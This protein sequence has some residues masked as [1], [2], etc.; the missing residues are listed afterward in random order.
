MAY[1]G[2]ATIQNSGRGRYKS[3]MYAFLH[4]M[5]VTSPIDM[6]DGMLGC[7]CLTW[8]TDDEVE[9]SLRP[10]TGSL[11]YGD[12]SVGTWLERNDCRLYKAV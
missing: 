4:Y 11:E 2:S 6:L 12:Q 9:H 3:Q 8:I 5:K 7:V 1:K 10:V